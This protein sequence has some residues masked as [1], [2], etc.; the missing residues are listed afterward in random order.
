MPCFRTRGIGAPLFKPFW[1][2]EGDADDAAAGLDAGPQPGRRFAI[3]AAVSAFA[4]VPAGQNFLPLIRIG[5]GKIPASVQR[6]TVRMLTRCRSA[7]TRVGSSEVASRSAAGSRFLR[8]M[9]NWL[10]D[11][12]ATSR[13][14]VEVRVTGK[15]QNRVEFVPQIERAA[16]TPVIAS[17]LV[18][19]TPV[20]TAVNTVDTAVVVTVG[21]M[22]F[23][24]SW[25]FPGLPLA[26]KK[27]RQRFG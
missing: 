24:G 1:W 9:E 8:D 6:S 4:T 17:V 19:N 3:Q 20:L 22:P 27:L 10:R 14:V 11:L 15:V 21:A 23:S 16:I 5:S 2:G 18:T 12:V 25:F 26:F 13:R 7:T